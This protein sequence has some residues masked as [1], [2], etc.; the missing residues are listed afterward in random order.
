ME[1]CLKTFVLVGWCQT[2]G[3]TYVK[4]YEGEETLN[5]SVHIRIS[6]FSSRNVCHVLIQIFITIH[7]SLFCW[8]EAGFMSW[9]FSSKL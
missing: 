8:Q 7:D 3:T 6:G 2:V 5:M 4:K 1:L 9:L